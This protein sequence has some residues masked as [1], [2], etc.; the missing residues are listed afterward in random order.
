MK[1]RI[2]KL[3][4]TARLMLSWL[5]SVDQKTYSAN[6]PYKSAG[7]RAFLLNQLF[8]FNLNIDLMLRDFGFDDALQRHLT[9]LRISFLTQQ[10]AQ[11]LAPDLAKNL[12][13]GQRLDGWYY[14]IRIEAEKSIK[15]LE[16]NC[17]IN[18]LSKWKLCGEQ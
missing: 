2:D 15:Y 10:L 13:P 7:I 11:K 12:N 9:H 3:L 1:C 8:N 18:R 4:K 17:F 6:M 16:A 5:N 14:E